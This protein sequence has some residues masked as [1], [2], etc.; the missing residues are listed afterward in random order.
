MLTLLRELRTEVQSMQERLTLLEY[1]YRHVSHPEE[2][3]E[4]HANIVYGRT[5]RD[6]RNRRSI[7]PRCL[8]LKET[9]TMILEFD[10]S[11]RHMLQEFINECTDVVQSINPADEESLIQAILYTKLKEK[12]MQ[13]FET[14]DIQ[15]YEELKQ[16][17]EATV[18]L[19]K[20]IPT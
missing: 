10:G 4:E 17:L 2:D 5:E 6:I 15:T 9:R 16:Q 14:R 19:P 13:D 3:N 1:G 20:R 8:P 18:R 7:A 11:S 12:A